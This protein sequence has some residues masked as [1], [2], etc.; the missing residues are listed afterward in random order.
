MTKNDKIADLIAKLKDLK[1]R[2][3]QVLL[4]LESLVHQNRPNHTILTVPVSGT[5]PI[6]VFA[7]GDCVVITNKTT[8]PLNCP[9]NNGDKTATVIK[10]APKRIDITTSN[11][12]ATWRSPNNLQL[13][14]IDE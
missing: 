12:F 14:R 10:V 9:K 5:V 11:G 6:P 13:R 3:L 4:S 7:V 2:E 1:L 8:R